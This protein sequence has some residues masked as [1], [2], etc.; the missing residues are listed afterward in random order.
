MKSERDRQSA[1]CIA[2]PYRDYALLSNG[3]WCVTAILL[4]SLHFRCNS[5]KD[6]RQS[7]R[8]LRSCLFRSASRCSPPARS[9]VTGIRKNSVYAALILARIGE[10]VK[11][12]ARDTPYTRLI[13]AHLAHVCSRIHFLFILF[14]FFI[15]FFFSKSCFILSRS[16]EREQSSPGCSRRDVTSNVRQ[17]ETEDLKRLT[18]G[19]SR[20]ED[21]IARARARSPVPPERVK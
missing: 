9:G 17:S 10:V 7:E 4:S 6:E 11:S 14:Q 2:S 15:L 5:G 16:R 19:A 12:R 21:A 3:A 20:R 13:V 8:R 1:R 18:R